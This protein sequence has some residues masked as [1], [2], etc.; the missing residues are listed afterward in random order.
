M[1]DMAEPTPAQLE[2]IQSKVR[3]GLYRS[4]SEFLREAIDE[5]LERLRR[6][7]VAQQVERYCTLN[8]PETEEEL[9][10]AQAF[11]AD[12]LETE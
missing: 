10:A 9:I 1:T 5:K 12:Q 3:A 7:R 8:D 11:D 4:T 6:D 2:E